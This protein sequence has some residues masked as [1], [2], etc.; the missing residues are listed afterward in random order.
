MRGMRWIILCGALR[1]RKARVLLSVSALTLG[2]ALI[3]TTV[4]LRQGIRGKLAAELQNYGAN[5]LVTPAPGA[6]PQLAEARLAV[7][8]G[9][10]TRGRLV[11]YAPVLYVRAK[12]GGRDVV[13]VGTDVAA[14]QR[15]SPWWKVAGA[16]PRRPDEALVGANA[17]AKLGLRVGDRFRAAQGAEALELAVAGILQTGDAEEHQ[18]FV[19]LPGAQRLAQRPGQI[20]SVLLRSRAGEGLEA[21]AAALQAAWPD[22][23][24][25]TLR[26][27]ALAEAALLGN[28]ER[29]LLAVSLLVLFAAGL[30]AFATM[31]TEA[32]ERKVEIALMRAL[33]ADGREIG[34]IFTCEA[35]GV[36][37]LAGLLGCVLGILLA[38]VIGMS[39][40]HT[41]VVPSFVSLPAGLLAGLLVSLLASLSVVRRAASLPPALVLRGE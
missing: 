1:H 24:V 35:L 41:L 8:E 17:A 21:L 11:G 32:L 6:A 9:E 29:F 22:A 33:G 38:L 31:N 25:R 20:T 36:G 40:F 28:L 13:V 15:I 4:N 30:C 18:V 26:Q 34:W 12:A 27:T 23:V 5:L 14:M 10:A 3:V 37:L 2:A 16:W 7:L 39:V 19:A